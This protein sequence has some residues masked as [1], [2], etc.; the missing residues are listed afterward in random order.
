MRHRVGLQ[1]WNHKRRPLSACPSFQLKQSCFQFSIESNSP[2]IVP[3]AG[4]F[5]IFAVL[6]HVHSVRYVPRYYSFHPGPGPIQSLPRIGPSTLP[7]FYVLMCSQSE[8]C[9]GF[10]AFDLYELL[11]SDTPTDPEYVRTAIT[12]QEGWLW[13]AAPL[14]MILGNGI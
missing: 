9:D 4:L 12:T 11:W 2:P 1:K 5:L 13:K 14:Y 3:T 8:R 7:F 10:N 6:R